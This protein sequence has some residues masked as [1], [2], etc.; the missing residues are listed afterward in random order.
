MPPRWTPPS[1]PAWLTP[2][3]GVFFIDQNGHRSPHSPFTPALHALFTLHPTFD[4]N[5]L[6]IITDCNSLRKLFRFITTRGDAAAIDKEFKI[7][8]EAI[9]NTVVFTRWEKETLE[10]DTGAFRGFGHTFEQ[11]FTKLARGMEGTTGHNRVCRYRFGGLELLVRFSADAFLRSR[12]LPEGSGGVQGESASPMGAGGEKE[13]KAESGAG[14]APEAGEKA[15]K[16]SMG[17]AGGELKQQKSSTATKSTQSE[18]EDEESPT[19]SPRVQPTSPT[20]SPSS[21]S[22]IDSP[23][24]DSPDDLADLFGNSLNLL[25]SSPTPPAADPTSTSPPA[26]LPLEIIPG[27][28]LMPQSRILEIKTRSASR[29]IDLTDQIPQLWFTH[30]QHLYV[31]YHHRGQFNMVDTKVMDPEALVRWE[32]APETQRQLRMLRGLLGR[33][34]EA[35]RGLRGGGGGEGGRA[36]VVCVGRSV[37]VYKVGEGGDR[38]ARG[39]LP[40][41]LRRRW[42]GG[43]KTLVEF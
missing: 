19:A 7:Y 35:V 43:E 20:T 16:E 30:T 40:A 13:G 11:K 5:P 32:E 22:L 26:S 33:I 6:D 10:A 28:T 18:D 34:V 8:A 25:P 21:T 14:S 29:F 3:T 37:R 38:Q 9:N 39:G 15:G 1:L 2:D 41:E 23:I 17:L 4:P 24:I 42:G 12:D 27:G 31:G 36:Q